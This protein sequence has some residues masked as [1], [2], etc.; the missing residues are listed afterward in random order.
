M[1]YYQQNKMLRSIIGKIKKKLRKEKEK[2]TEN[3]TNLKKK[4][5]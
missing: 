4:T 2:G 3:W 5:K 1:N